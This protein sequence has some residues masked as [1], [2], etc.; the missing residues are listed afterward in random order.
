MPVDIESRVIPPDRVDISLDQVFDEWAVKLRDG[1]NAEWPRDTGFSQWQIERDGD[2][3]TVFTP[4][5]YAART[6]KAGETEPFLEVH[7]PEI[8]AMVSAETSPKF[9]EV[10]RNMISIFGDDR[11]RS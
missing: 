3:Q 2:D 5:D 7:A 4:A 11:G 10:A 1:I 6:H 9:A 8:V